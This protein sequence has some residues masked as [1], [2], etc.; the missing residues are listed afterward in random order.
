MKRINNEENKE[1][2]AN[3]AVAATTTILSRW[4]LRGQVRVPVPPA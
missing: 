1:W 3:R 2:R 4:R